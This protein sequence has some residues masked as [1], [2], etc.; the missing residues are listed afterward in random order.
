MNEL[1]KK[2]PC[3]LL[4][5]GFAA[6]AGG[7]DWP[8]FRGA[9][10]SGV[11]PEVGLAQ[12][13]PAG[14]PKVL[15]TVDVGEGF[16]G[17]AIR[18]AEVYLLDRTERQDV[19]RCLDLATGKELW[20]WSY[21]A[22][23]AFQYNG[24]R[25]VPTV[26]DRHIYALG[27]FGHLH[28]I[29]CRTHAVVWKAHLV[30][31]FKD[32]QIDGGPPPKNRARNLLRAQVPE[33]G[34]T[35]SP[36]IWRD[37]LI[38]A[39]QTQKVGV[40]AYEKN[41]GRIRWTTPYIG[42]NWY[43]HVTPTLLRLCGVEQIVMLAQPSD[44]ERWPPANVCGI[45]PQSGR[46]LWTTQ[47]PRPHKIPIPL[48]V[49]LGDDRVLITGGYGLGCHILKVRKDLD[50]WS[51]TW[52]SSSREIA[53]HIHSPVVY[54]NRVFLT[55]FREHGATNTGLVCLDLE[56]KV[57]WQTGP[58]LQ[59]DSGAYL[60][61]DDLAFIMHGRTGELSLLGI[62]DD[63]FELLGKAKVLKGEGGL[64]WG[65]MALSNGKLIVRDQH[66]LK[67]LDVRP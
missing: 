23:G 33:W 48:P 66:Q 9:D 43:S 61:A 11:S 2:A 49:A 58:K 37:L 63:G 20:N 59:F 51:A 32:P 1:V 65:P 7:A 52:V 26:D 56:G 40:V 50:A 31:D 19:L 46:I 53:G 15:W 55:S 39:P 30:D 67:C 28:C 13:W 54:K 5:L 12:G 10:R 8:Q 4:V 35:Q 6:V 34:L 44:P 14:G 41:T 29:D 60:I 18:A 64:V 42:R 16:G 62:R 45:D 57:T 3:V 27:A 17:A 22:P 24:S 36:L 38:V 47:T 21:D 25:N